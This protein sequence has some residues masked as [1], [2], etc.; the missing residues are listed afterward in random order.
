M[1][2]SGAVLLVELVMS[3]D[4]LVEAARVAGPTAAGSWNAPAILGHVGEVDD[5]V[6][7]PRLDAMLTAHRSGAAA[8]VS[9][10]WEPDSA[11]TLDRWQGSSLDDAAAALMAARTRLVGRC[12]GLSA[13]DW[14]ATL[15][16]TT[17]GSLDITGVLLRV[18]EHDETHRA[19]LVLQRP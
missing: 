5:V 10:W 18:L 9:D 4:R 11:A 13:D 12:R 19:S 17:F 7:G 15:D 3:A 8:P 6:W 1:A 2:I 16:H 14:G